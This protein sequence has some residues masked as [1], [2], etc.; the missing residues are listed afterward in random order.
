M[1]ASAVLNLHMT[2]PRPYTHLCG[3][4]D[5]IRGN[6]FFFCLMAAK[7]TTQFVLIGNIKA[8]DLTLPSHVR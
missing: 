3:R 6:I 2:H 5:L 4:G 1:P 8:F 7:I